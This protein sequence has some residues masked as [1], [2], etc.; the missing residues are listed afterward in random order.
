M[1][2]AS[3]GGK[4]IQVL[5]GPKNNGMGLTPDSG[6]QALIQQAKDFNMHLERKEWD[7]ESVQSET[8]YQ[9]WC[10]AVILS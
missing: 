5:K 3:E 10:S 1:L 2:R 6:W 7:D 4:G 9:Q 8:A